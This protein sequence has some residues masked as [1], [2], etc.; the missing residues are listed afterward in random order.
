[1]SLASGNLLG[2]AL[3]SHTLDDY[4]SALAWSPDAQRVAAGSLAGDAVLVDPVDGQAVADLPAHPM[5][6]LQAAWSPDGARLATGGQDGV[7]TLHDRNGR[8]IAT[9]AFD[10]WVSALAWKPDGSLLATGSG[11]HVRLVEPDGRVVLVSEPTTSTVTSLAWAVNKRRVAAG[12]YGGVGWYELEHGPRP[13]KHFEWK[14]S[15]LTLAAS[16]DGRW[17]T[18]GA[19]DQTVHIWRLWS[20]DELSMQ[21]YP[22]K[23]EHL[24]WHHTSKWLA[25]GNLGEITLWDCAGRGPSGRRPRQLDGHS[26]HISALGFQPRGDLLASGG[27]DGLVLLWDSA[28]KGTDPVAHI[29]TD[30]TVSALAWSPSGDRLIIAAAG[31]SLTC[32]AV[33]P[34][35]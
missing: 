25:V 24:A 10:R 3:W 7:L 5:G 4:V 35:S 31:G 9:D 8:T 22:T 18:A 21:G 28:T 20:A 27:A 29:E 26:R 19:Q 1:M 11:R 2:S 17:L 15:I 32:V 23:V 12:C 6:V 34:D 16:P 33:G 30:E 14:G 13:T